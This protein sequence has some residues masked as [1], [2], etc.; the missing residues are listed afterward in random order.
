MSFNRV[1]STLRCAALSL[2]VLSCP[3]LAVAQ[4]TPDSRR[5][6]ALEYHKVFPMKEM[7]ADMQKNM[8]DMSAGFD[9]MVPPAQRET[10]KKQQEEQSKRMLATIDAKALEQASIDAMVKHFTTKEIQA[11]ANFYA[12]PEGRAVMKKMPQYTADLMPQVQKEMMKS[13]FQVKQ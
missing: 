12:S 13:L 11:L 2:V 4:D 7:I 6:A 9:Q 8:R 5:A 10:F 1:K 3:L